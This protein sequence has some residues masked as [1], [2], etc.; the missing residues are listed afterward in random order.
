MG[1]V[2]VSFLFKVHNVIKSFGVIEAMWWYGGWEQRTMWPRDL[3]GV[4]Q[5]QHKRL[6]GSVNCWPR[7]TCW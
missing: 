4:V 1:P 3:E 5:C 6:T 2:E 7:Y